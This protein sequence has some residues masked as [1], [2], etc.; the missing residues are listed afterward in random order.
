MAAT[1]TKD[2]I[3]DAAK[4]IML[5]KSFHSVGLNEILTAVKVPKGSFYHYFASKEQ[6]GAELLQHYVA[7]HSE[8]M[9]QVLLSQDLNPLQRLVAFMEGTAAM[10]RMWEATAPVQAPPTPFAPRRGR[11]E[12]SRAGG[13]SS[14]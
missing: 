5:Q 12:S 10:M 7:Q 3:L 9:R 11:G 14:A 2:R 13:A 4:E 1:T 6:F 8:R